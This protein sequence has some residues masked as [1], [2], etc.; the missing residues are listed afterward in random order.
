MLFTAMTRAKGWVHVSGVG[1]GAETCKKEI[2]VALADFPYIRFVY[3]GPEQLKV[4]RRDLA[5]DAIRKQEARRM[6]EQLVDEYG[7]SPE[8]LSLFVQDRKGKDGKGRKKRGQ[9]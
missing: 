6:M 4:M 7:V 8:E 3:P 9:K 2:D 1:T 5:A